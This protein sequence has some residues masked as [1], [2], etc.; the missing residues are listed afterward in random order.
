LIALLDHFAAGCRC[1]SP[2]LI[3]PAYAYIQEGN[4]PLARAQRKAT[5]IFATGRQPEWQL[6]YGETGEGIDWAAFAEVCQELLTPMWDG[7]DVA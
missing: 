1:P 3:E 6:L 5:D 7:A 4:N 2:L